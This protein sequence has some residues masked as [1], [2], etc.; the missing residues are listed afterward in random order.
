[1]IQDCPSWFSISIYIPCLKVEGPVVAVGDADAGLEVARP[2]GEDDVGGD[3]ELVEGEG[4]GQL[5][6]DV[7]GQAALLAGRDLG[8]LGGRPLQPVFSRLDVGD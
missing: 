4:E 2:G 8:G 5:L 6:G 7:D 1:M 3:G